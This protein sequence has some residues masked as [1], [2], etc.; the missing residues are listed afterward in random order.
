MEE[1]PKAEQDTPSQE[2]L[3]TGSVPDSQDVRADRGSVAR[4]CDW[5]PPYKQHGTAL[6][7]G[8]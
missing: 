2:C 3:T 1:A 4:C 7:C 8:A 6:I 5:N